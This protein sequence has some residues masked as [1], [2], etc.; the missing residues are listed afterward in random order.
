MHFVGLNDKQAVWLLQSDATFTRNLFG[1]APTEAVRFPCHARQPISP[2]DEFTLRCIGMNMSQREELVSFLGLADEV[3]RP[4]LASLAQSEQIAL[5]A[6]TGHNGWTLTSLGKKA[7]D[8]AQLV[9]AEE[10]MVPLIFDE[11]VSR[12]PVK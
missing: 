2:I 3:I 10:R 5:T 7:L 12:F 4:V 1:A 6:V 9:V 11:L 8:A